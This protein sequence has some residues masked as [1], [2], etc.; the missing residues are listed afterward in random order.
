[1]MNVSRVSP[2]MYTLRLSL[3]HP[4]SPPLQLVL[5]LPPSCPGSP[6]DPGLLAGMALLLSVPVTRLMNVLL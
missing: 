5:E 3:W 4:L 2:N 6:G 1:M